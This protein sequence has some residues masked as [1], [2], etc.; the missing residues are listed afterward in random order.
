MIPK[1]SISVPAGAHREL[2]FTPKELRA[3]ASSY[4]LYNFR[5]VDGALVLTEGL[6]KGVNFKDRFTRIATAKK[7]TI[8][9]Y[10]F[11][12]SEGEVHFYNA[13]GINLTIRGTYSVKRFLTCPIPEGDTAYVTVSPR[14][15]VVNN[16][17]GN[18]ISLLELSEGGECGAVYFERFFTAEGDIVRYAALH[19]PH[20]LLLKCDP[21]DDP[22]AITETPQGAGRFRMH[23]RAFGNI[24]EMASYREGLYFFRERGVTRLTGGADPTDFHLEDLHVKGYR[25]PLSE[26]L[27]VCG[28]LVYY[29]TVDGKLCSF[30][31]EKVQELDDPVV[32][33][34]DFTSAVH[35][36][37]HD[38]RYYCLVVRT[39]G[40]KCIYCYDPISGAGFFFAKGLVAL[41]EGL[42]G[43]L[44]ISSG[45]SKRGWF[46]EAGTNIVLETTVEPVSDKTFVLESIAVEGKGTF[47]VTISTENEAR[48]LAA[49]AGECVHLSTP[50]RAKEFKVKIESDYIESVRVEGI[51]LCGTE[52]ARED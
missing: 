28:G 35:A 9:T 47:A 46:F 37:R 52:V 29:F 13:I 42:T 4:Y 15:L 48:E 27:I 39:D 1:K 20:A 23:D 2:Y 14:K 40:D 50:L 10:M 18:R 3:R 31:G 38:G 44:G 36:E 34:I 19:D 24:V 45:F 16:A 26:S 25:A 8:D 22:S 11:F 7:G 30:N 5:E 32:R 33:F 41:G 21:V 17:S 49:V 51:R 43:Q 12:K 6:T